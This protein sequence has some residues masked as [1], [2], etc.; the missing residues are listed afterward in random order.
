MRYFSK[1]RSISERCFNRVVNDG[2]SVLYHS[3]SRFSICLRND[4][5]YVYIRGFG[6]SRF[7]LRVWSISE[8]FLYCREFYDETREV[9]F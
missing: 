1:I 6:Y 3:G 9:S 4:F 7:D 2:V 5:A 8:V